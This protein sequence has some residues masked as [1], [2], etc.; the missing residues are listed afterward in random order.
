MVVWVRNQNN[1]RGHACT[2]PQYKGPLMD[3]GIDTGCNAIILIITLPA[4]IS[5]FNIRRCNWL[6]NCFCGENV[7]ENGNYSRSVTEEIDQKLFI[8]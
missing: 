7:Q 2:S 6:C 1:K 4:L 3:Y 5:G 8:I